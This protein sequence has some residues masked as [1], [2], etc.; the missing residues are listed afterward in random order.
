MS[1][2]DDEAMIAAYLSYYRHKDEADS[3]AFD[4]VDEKS[5][6]RAALPFIVKL[7]EACQTEREI[8]YVAAGPLED[9]FRQYYDS[10]EKELSILVRKHKKMRIAIQ[11]IW[12]GNEAEAK[13][14]SR[15][16]DKYV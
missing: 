7:I 4:K 3:W 16:L 8:C 14:L 15:I 9:F 13:V 6:E 11:A 2:H 5:K 12:V 1:N 10:I